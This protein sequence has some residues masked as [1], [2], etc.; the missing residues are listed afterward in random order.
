MKRAEAQETEAENPTTYS[1]QGTT[2]GSA[3]S[4]N[5]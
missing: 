2:E 3:F 5:V 1:S 4:H